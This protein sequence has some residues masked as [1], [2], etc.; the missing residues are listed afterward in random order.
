MTALP[1]V[2]T[3]CVDS[4]DEHSVCEPVVVEMASPTEL[5]ETRLV[6]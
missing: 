2:E 5:R 3:Q 4:S 6:E 1:I